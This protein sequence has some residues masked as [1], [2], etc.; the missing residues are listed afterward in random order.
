MIFISVWADILQNW[1]ELR[2]GLKSISSHLCAVEWWAIR[3]FVIS[4]YDLFSHW[5]FY[6]PLAGRIWHARSCSHRKEKN[7]F[8]FASKWQLLCGHILRNLS[9]D[10]KESWDE[11][12]MDR[13]YFAL[14]DSPWN[15]SSNLMHPGQLQSYSQESMSLRN[16][17]QWTTYI[18]EKRSGPWSP[19]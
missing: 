18:A 16:S 13:S 5:L 15:L 9:T 12:M 1:K 8:F 4:T 19:L 17:I 10:T 6:Q 2:E 3:R 11:Y 7:C 14:L